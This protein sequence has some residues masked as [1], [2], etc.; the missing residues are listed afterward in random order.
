LTDSGLPP[1][2][3][4]PPE[5][6]LCDQFGV[7]RMTLR[8][9]TAMLER[10]GLLL[11]QR[12]RGTFVAHD[13]LRKQQQEMRSFS[14]EILARGG[15]PK[16]KL[17]SAKSGP[18][19]EEARAFF[20]LSTEDK[21][22]EIKRTRMSDG[23]P[24]A[25]ETVWLSER[26][27]P[28]LQRFD[29]AKNSL[30]RILEDSYGIRLE[31]CVEEVSAA[32]ATAEQRELLDLPRNVA[33]LVINRKTYTDAGRPLEL[34]RSAYRGDRYSAVVHSVRRKRLGEK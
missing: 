6:A 17:L 28:N 9:A 24:L 15:V 5:R 12:G 23:V 14:E 20:G 26:L 8:Q 30:Y 11:S 7:S 29:L 31:N 32:L 25:F 21:I 22:Y 19:P 2:Y 3:P 1:G 16:S 27:C 33:V 34:A 4:L 18:V 13:L 10:E